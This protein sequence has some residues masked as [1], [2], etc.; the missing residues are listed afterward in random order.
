MNNEMTKE[1][2][3]QLIREGIE[4]L[5]SDGEILG[6]TEE[7]KRVLRAM[8]K[9][10]PELFDKVMQIVNLVSDV[11]KHLENRAEIIRSPS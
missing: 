6:E 2:F 5:A 11:K 7:D 1:E 9:F 8:A 3:H 10:D 4:D